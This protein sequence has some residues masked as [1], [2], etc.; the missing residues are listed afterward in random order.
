MKSL[1]QIGELSLI[2]EI[3]RFC[4][5]GSTVRKGIGDDAAVVK[6][7]RNRF[8]LF[9]TDMLIENVHFL[10]KHDLRDV[11]HKA[12][13][14][15]ISDIA[16]MGGLPQYALLSVAFPGTLKLEQ[17]RRFY[18]GIR[19]TAKEFGVKVVG[20]DTNS[21]DRIII[22]VFMCGTV[23]R[24]NLVLREGAQTGDR[25]FVTGSLGGSLKGRH[26][27]F[28]PRLREARF[29]VENFKL[30]SLMDISDGLA[31]DL[32]RLLKQSKK[33]ALLNAAK[34]PLSAQARTPDQAF[35][36]G[37]DF[38]LLFTLNEKEARKLEKT[39][40]KRQKLRLSCIGEIGPGVRPQIRIKTVE[41]TIK[42]L[43]ILGYE[44]FKTK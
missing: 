3:G 29:L 42:K 13:A 28:V 34:I 40:P 10:R 22:D 38:E 4:P 17:V 11:A 39:W 8:L 25:I 2:E 20:G 37:E 27:K 6:S 7:G 19:K 44:H 32:F 23:E 35:Y 30:N 18:S 5:S 21:A 41:G 14:C 1:K 16:A 12:L 36:D 24:R 9:T 33:S 31:L 26:L 43:K 15:S